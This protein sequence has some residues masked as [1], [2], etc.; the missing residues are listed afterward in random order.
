ML[1]S[2]ILDGHYRTLIVS[3]YPKDRGIY[4]FHMPTASICH[5]SNSSSQCQKTYEIWQFQNLITGHISKFETIKFGIEVCRDRLFWH[6][7]LFR[8]SSE[9]WWFFACFC[10]DRF[11]AGHHY[12]HIDGVSVITQTRK[13]GDRCFSNLACPL[14]MISPQ[15]R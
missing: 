1:C 13:A 3:P 12:V 6:K 11:W 14:V 9:V 15:V 2:C 4:R 10:I 7:F 8:R 5:E